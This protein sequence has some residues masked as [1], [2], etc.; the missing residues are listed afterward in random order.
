MAEILITG[1]AGYIGSMLV[2]HL[3]R[4]AVYEDSRF[5]LYRGDIRDE[6]A[7]ADAMEGV[8][9]VVHLAALVGE[10]MCKIQPE[11]A[12]SVNVTG[13][14]K[15][16][17]AA[18]R[19]GVEHFAL[20]STCSNYG[21]AGGDLVNEET[22]LF[23]T[24]P[25]SSSKIMAERVVLNGTGIGR[26]VFRFATVFGISGRMRYDLLINQFA[27]DAVLKRWLLV[28]GMQSR[29][30]FV[31]VR[32][33]VRVFDLWLEHA[34]SMDGQIYNVGG[35]NRTKRQIVECLCDLV[36]DL[37]VE[38]RRGGSDPRDYAVDFR[39]IKALGYEPAITPEH[40]LAMLV[41]SL[42]D[43]LVQD[44]FEKTWRNQ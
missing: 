8:D 37:E 6:K 24:G 44:P 4:L 11:E 13:T 30:P 15:V 2:A 23:G 3:L 27:C 16:M 33:L 35:W 25:Y 42:F 32:D 34:D 26:T 40:G 28:Y 43:G 31:H 36:V 9:A 10:P 17:S 18:A 5:D 38:E 21:S 22:P 14:E 29:R 12:A 7:L 20:A 1:G 19:A 39:K 41:R